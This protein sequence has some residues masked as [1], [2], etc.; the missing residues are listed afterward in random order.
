MATKKTL[1]E[2]KK[3]PIDY[4]YLWASDE[5]ISQLGSKARVIKQKKYNQ[6]Q[7]LWKAVVMNN[8]NASAEKLQEVYKQWTSEIASVIKNTYGYTPGEILIRLAMGQEV[9]GKNFK[10]GV[11]GV[12][13]T[14]TTSF[15]QNSNY[16]VNP[17]TGQIMAG[18]GEI[19]NPTPVYDAN[20][21]VGGYSY[22]VGNLQFQS[23]YQ[24]GQF[25]ALSYSNADG[26]QDANGNSFNASNASFWQNANNYMPIVNSVLSWVTSIVNSYF[27]NRTVLTPQNTVPVQTE[28]V[29]AEDNN[30]WLIAGGVAAIGVLLLTMANP[31]GGKRKK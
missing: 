30:G 10:K 2:I 25:V 23:A 7:T 27:P 19:G 18:G 21:N 13:N 9:A 4:L 6:Y 15:L 16:E 3:C 20:G 24:D 5:F 11:Y 29:E 22:Q 26:V 12:G 17:T 14:P 31:F 28:W 1:A 8:E